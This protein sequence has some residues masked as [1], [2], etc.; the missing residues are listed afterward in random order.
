MSCGIYKITN[1]INNKVYIGQSINIEDRWKKHKYAKDGFAIHQAIQKYGVDNFT[2][3]I[4]EEC[5]KELLDN[6]EI[7]WISYYN[8]LKKGYNMIPGGSNGV[9]YTKGIPVEQY[10][11]DGIYINTYDSAKQASEI[12]GIVHTDICKCCREEILRAGKY[13]WKYV[14]S[15]KRVC[16]I[17]INSTTIQRPVNQYSLDGQFICQYETLA[18]ASKK[19]GITKTIICNVCKGKGHTAGGFRW[20]YEGEPL[21]I[22]PHGRNKIVQQYSLDGILLKEYNSLTEASRMTN[23][24]TGLISEVCNGKKKQGKG[25][26]W[27][28]K[29]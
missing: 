8:S 15:N 24:S 7:Y 29:L 12:T 28:Y 19:T 3:E 23:I 17:N 10:S 11:L 1:T 5:P 16:P 18:Q 9:G 27:K 2:F 20:A 6:R 25:F 21:I 26:I 4:L 13:Q 14:D 22:K